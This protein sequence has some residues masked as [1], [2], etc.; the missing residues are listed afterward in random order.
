M[1]HA[2]LFSGVGGFDLAAVWAGFENIFNCEIDA[3]CRKV[4]KYHFANSKQH[5]NIREVDFRPY[6]GIIDVLTGGFPCQPFSV[7]GSR[8][9]TA[10]D[11]YLWPEFLRAIREIRPR[12][13]I[14]ENVKGI[15][16][17]V[18]PDSRPVLEGNE[19]ESI[20][21]GYRYIA[22]RICEDLEAEGYS[23]QPVVIPACAVGAP[24]RRDRVWFVAYSGSFGRDDGI[25]NRSGRRIQTDEFRDFQENKSERY[26]RFG[27]FG[28]V[29]SPATDTYGA[30]FQTQGSK[31]Q[32]TGFEQHGKLGKID[33]DTNKLN[34]DLSGFRTSGLSQFKTPGVRENCWKNFPT[35]SPVCSGDDGIPDG[36]DGITVSKWRTESIKAYGNA[37][38]PQVAFEILTLIKQISYGRD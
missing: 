3:F 23:V 8:K 14:G 16:S 32:T 25:D 29:S 27:G 19:T 38:V 10:D 21:T 5:G 37:I 22:D 26:K 12:W 20:Q 4:L 11:R 34:G 17:M 13:I 30:G 15:L 7:A 28:K 31:Q 1:T 2:S 35:E 18:E 33:T 9:G 24:H 6:R 36:L